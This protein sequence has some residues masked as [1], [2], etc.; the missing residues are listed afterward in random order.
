MSKTSICVKCGSSQFEMVD[1][2]KTKNSHVKLLF[3]QC[4]SCGGV[5]GTLDYRQ[6]RL[7]EAIAKKVGVHSI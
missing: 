3:I 7:I 5:I 2:E 6:Q 1:D 4:A